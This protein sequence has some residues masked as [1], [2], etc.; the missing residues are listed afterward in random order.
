[1]PL[2]ILLV[3]LAV[4]VQLNCSSPS[5]EAKT[6]DSTTYASLDPNNHYVGMLTCREC[7]TSI[8][9]SYIQTGMGQSMD[10]AS[11]RKSSGNFAQHQPVYDPHLNFWYQPYWDADSLKIMEYRLE[12]KDTVFKRVEQ[13]T[14]IVGSG[15]HTN[16]HIMSTL[17]YLNQMPL[18]YYTQDGKWD[19]PPGFENGGNSRFS[20]LIGLECITCHNSYPEFVVGSEN[21]FDF[22]DR[23][24]NCERCHG[25]GGKHVEEKRKGIAVDVVTGIDYTIVN[26]AKLPIDLQLDVCQRCHIQGNAVLKDGKTFFDFKPGMKLSDVMDVYMPV[27]KGREHEHI[28]ASH[29]ERMKLSRCF[30]VSAANVQ[31][32]SSRSLR[33]YKDALTCVTCHN[34]HVSVKSTGNEIFNTACKNCHSNSKNNTCTESKANLLAVQNNCVSCHMPKSGT[35]DIP[36]VSVHDHFIRI[37]VKEKELENIRQFA[38]INCINNPEADSLSVARAYIAY[39]EKFNFGKEVLDSAKKYLASFNTENNIQYIEFAIHIAYLENNYNKVQTLAGKFPNYLDDVKK[40]SSDN[41][42]AYTAYRIGQSY[43]ET[44]NYQVAE[45]YLHKAYK[46]APNIQ[47]FINKYATTLVNLNR[48]EEAR[49]VLQRGVHDY[50]KFPPTITNL[51]Y[52]YL[53]LDKDYKRAEQLYNRALALDP[54]YEQAIINKAG[55]MMLTGRPGEARNLL[56]RYLKRKP[57]NQKII[58]LLGQIPT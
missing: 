22:I 45:K 38:G 56:S 51:G 17:G 27:Y 24:I 43:L 34:P 39:F 48:P 35:T 37:P 21:R 46:L 47:D 16:S 52:L 33:P 10:L 14:Y 3:P 29:V 32:S 5:R 1:L 18:T 15:Q 55:L 40:G 57:G 19:L 28:M 2:F 50:G 54:D 9:D 6:V 42:H 49:K 36:H 31:S 44:G 20:R 53:I 58:E 26:P 13:V 23:G 8:Y 4:F 30:T 25:P 7:H 11:K 41:R 12:G